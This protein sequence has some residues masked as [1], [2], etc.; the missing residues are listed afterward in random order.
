M[1]KRKNSI[2]EVEGKIRGLRRSFKEE[3]APRDFGKI[4]RSVLY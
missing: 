3:K 4:P 1:Y 2:K